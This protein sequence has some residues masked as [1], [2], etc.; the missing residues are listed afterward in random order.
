[1][2]TL[3]EDLPF[4]QLVRS[5]M[6]ERGVG[7]RQLCR[8]VGVDPSYFSKVLMSKRN[9]PTEENVLEKIAQALDMDGPHLI[10]SAGRI[11]RQWRRIWDEPDLFRKIHGLLSNNPLKPSV[12]VVSRPQTRNA[13]V[14]KARRWAR[15]PH[16]TYVSKDLDEELL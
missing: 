4:A 8:E 9:P 14:S 6:E 10:V 11:P 15:R 16:V 5:R 1:M 7:L 2:T 13:P 3:G 12:A